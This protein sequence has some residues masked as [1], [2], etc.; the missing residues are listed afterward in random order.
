MSTCPVRARATSGI[1]SIPRHSVAIMNNVF[2]AA[3]CKH[4]RVRARVVCRRTISDVP[5]DPCKGIARG[6]LPAT[7]EKA[8]TVA[9]RYRGNVAVVADVAAPRARARDNEC[10]LSD[11]LRARVCVES[12]R[13]GLV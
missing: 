4:L 2:C 10:S 11:K 9:T 3:F 7:T 8:A 1:L 13:E 5:L 12:V 6:Y